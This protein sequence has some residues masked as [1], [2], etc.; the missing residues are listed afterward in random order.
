MT[1]RYNIGCENKLQTAS[2]D[3]P[4]PEPSGFGCDHN[5]GKCCADLPQGGAHQPGKYFRTLLLSPGD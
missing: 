3:Q 2:P 1:N 4:V 5:A